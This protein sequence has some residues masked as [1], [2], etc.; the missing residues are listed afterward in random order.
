MTARK[1]ER[2][3]ILPS[4]SIPV[5]DRNTCASARLRISPA[6][7]SEMPQMS[8]LPANARAFFGPVEIDFPRE[9]VSPQYQGSR[10]RADH[11]AGS[12]ARGPQN[13][14]PSLA[15]LQRVLPYISG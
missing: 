2:M 3:N 10:G 6:I 11:P 13:G 12:A 14:L 1:R 7:A 9:I 4:M 15:I 5:T 8:P